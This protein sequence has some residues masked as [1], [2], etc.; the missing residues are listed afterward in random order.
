MALRLRVAS[1]SSPSG[2]MCKQ[3]CPTMWHRA[4]KS[5]EPLRVSELVC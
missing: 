2:E 5:S 3:S 1:W 4:S